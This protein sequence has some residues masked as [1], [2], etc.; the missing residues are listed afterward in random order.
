MR[1]HP[2]NQQTCV[3]FLQCGY[4][5]FKT[6]SRVALGKHVEKKHPMDEDDD[7][8]ELPKRK[9]QTRQLTRVFKKKLSKQLIS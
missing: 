3:R 8:P 4:C 7:V 9:I 5:S 1:Y 2:P 6:T